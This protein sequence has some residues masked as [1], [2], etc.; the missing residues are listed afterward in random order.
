MSAPESGAGTYNRSGAHDRSSAQPEVLPVRRVSDVDALK[1]LADPTRLRMLRA[2]MGTGTGGDLPVVSVKE[3]AEQLGEPQTKL[4]RHVKVLE[5]AG[6]IHVAATRL[7]SGIVEQR[8]QASQHDVIFHGPGL[9]A[10]EG[11]VAQNA[12]AAVAT[13]LDSYRQRLFTAARSGQLPAGTLDS[14]EPY[15][16]TMLLLNEARVSRERAASARLK[17]QE[18]LDELGDAPDDPDGISVNVLI[19]FFSPVEEA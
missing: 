10:P 11:A 3:L 5:S 7:V 6:L 4:Y 8:Y 14:D 2:M 9:S 12:E 19:G 16:S 15:R 18:V 17:L 13:V 1:A